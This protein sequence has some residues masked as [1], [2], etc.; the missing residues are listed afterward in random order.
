MKGYSSRKDI[1]G[2]NVSASPQ[3][4]GEA[5]SARATKMH[6]SISNEY[7][8]WIYGF[9]AIFGSESGFSICPIVRNGGPQKR[10]TYYCNDL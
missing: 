1:D 4:G 5:E 2:R 3:A 8:D 6:N 10:N 7:I 9:R